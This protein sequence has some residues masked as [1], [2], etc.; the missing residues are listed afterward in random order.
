ML[1]PAKVVRRDGPR[2]RESH[3]GPRHS[4]RLREKQ[5]RK[6]TCCHIPEKNEIL[7]RIQIGNSALE[8]NLKYRVIRRLSR[9]DQSFVGSELS[10]TSILKYHSWYFW[11]NGDAKPPFD[12]GSRFFFDSTGEIVKIINSGS[13]LAMALLA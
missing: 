9:Q 3:L 4:A 2:S 10:E 11:E 1:I 13:L 7:I 8:E 6:P 12:V 5:N